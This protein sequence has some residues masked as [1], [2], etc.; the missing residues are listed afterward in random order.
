M[1]FTLFVNVKKYENE[2]TLLYDNLRDMQIISTEDP[3][4]TFLNLL[5]N[6]NKYVLHAV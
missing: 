5:T 6:S 4:E 3:K 1:R 2:R